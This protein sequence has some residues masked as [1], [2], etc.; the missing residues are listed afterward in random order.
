MNNLPDILQRILA[1]K[2]E[3]IQEQ[4]LSLR[5][6]GNKI[7]SAPPIRNFAA[8]LR[9]KI[10]SG[11]TAVIAEIKRASPS[12]GIIR[13]DFDPAA[14]AINYEQFGATCISVLTDRDFFHGA[15]EH[16]IQARNACSLPILRKDFII[17]PY[18]IYVARIL[19]A[20][21]ILLI[22]AALGDPLLQELA[23]LASELN[24]DVLIEIHSIMELRRILELNLI[25]Q[26]IIGINNRDLRTF[27]VNLQTTLDVLPLIPA[28]FLVVTESGI[29]TP[30]DVI[31]LRRAGVSIFLVGEVLMRVAN[32]GARLAEL[33][34]AQYKI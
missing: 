33:F 12:K 17:D 18:Q 14:I 6:L 1:R 7:D 30:N 27:Q 19:G 10:T 29:S 22:G 16:L 20:D 15:D 24:M 8:A 23:N 3:E 26:P 32:P 4:Q 11:N 34:S 28:H 13:E 9:K 21:A 31:T 25:S 5:D 2:A